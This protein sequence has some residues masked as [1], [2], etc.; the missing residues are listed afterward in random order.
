VTRLMKRKIH[1]MHPRPVGKTS[2]RRFAGGLSYSLL[3]ICLCG[4]VAAADNH[5]DINADIHIGVP[6]CASSVCHGKLSKQDNENVW[7]NEFRIWS[8]E[9]NHARAYKVL[10]NADSKRIAQNLGLKSAHTADICLDC[11]ADNVPADKRGEKFQITDGV[12]CEACH[13]GAERWIE[14]HTET[15]ASHA[16]NLA[17]GMY[18]TE[19]PQLRAALC[20]KCHMGSEDQFATHRIM[21][22]GHP[23]LSFELQLFTDIQPAHYDVDD[24]YIARKRPVVGF[25]LWLSGQLA[26]ADTYLGLLQSKLLQD[27]G[28]SPEFSL[29]DCHS[30]HH[31]MDD[32]RWGAQRRSQGLTPGQLR[33]QDQHLIMLKAVASA[34]SKNQRDELGR[35]IVSLLKAGQ[36]SYAAIRTRSAALQAWLN[37]H[38]RQWLAHEFTTADMRAIRKA[39]AQSGANGELADYAAAEQAAIGIENLS[40]NIGDASSQQKVLDDLYVAVESDQSYSPSKFRAASRVALGHF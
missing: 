3:L 8:N 10:L 26:A 31:S 2:M 1:P 30:C 12:G 34:V 16:D 15:D 18:P 23:R 33:L 32:K 29:M 38:G 40:I 14:S 4:G 25:N 27:T 17:A 11:H 39:L 22:A 19:D 5:V 37:E 21:G 13:G 28:I 35:S 24:D 36:T 7:L 9:D 6:S 20:L